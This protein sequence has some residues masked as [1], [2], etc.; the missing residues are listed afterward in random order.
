MCS[1]GLV[2]VLFVGCCLG[3]V[4]GIDFECLDGLCGGG[5]LF[6]DLG[7]LVC[8]VGYFVFCNGI[9]LVGFCEV[10]LFG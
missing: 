4:G 8:G 3:C 7:G 6:F 5:R 10:I 9:V 2:L 1:D